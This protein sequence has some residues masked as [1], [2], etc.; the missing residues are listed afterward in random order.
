MLHE[1][2]R[3]TRAVST[4]QNNLTI[5]SF[6]FFWFSK[7][8]RTGSWTVELPNLVFACPVTKI[9]DSRLNT[10]TFRNNI[11]M[12]ES[13]RSLKIGQKGKAQFVTHVWLSTTRRIYLF[14]AHIQNSHTIH[15]VAAVVLTGQTRKWCFLPV[16]CFYPQHIVLEPGAVDGGSLFKNVTPQA[17]VCCLLFNRGDSSQKQKIKKKKH[18]SLLFTVQKVTFVKTWALIY[19]CCYNKQLHCL[20]DTK[21][22]GK[23]CCVLLA[24]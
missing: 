12:T 2:T 1:R 21:C 20:S 10:W 19:G 7:K 13:T 11:W 15:E 4:F 24:Q 16:T 6:F 18:V 17:A 9:F 23:S 14:D 5:L 22:Q 8:F 3:E